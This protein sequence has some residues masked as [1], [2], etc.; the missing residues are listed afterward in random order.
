[1]ANSLSS[2]FTQEALGDIAEWAVA[3]CLD[4]YGKVLNVIFC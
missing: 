4:T 3:Y 1:M 2:A